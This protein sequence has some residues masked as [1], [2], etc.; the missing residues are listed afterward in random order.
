LRRRKQCTFCSV[1]V[2]ARLLTLSFPLRF[3]KWLNYLDVFQ[4]SDFEYVSSP[5][6]AV[7]ADFSNPLRYL[8]AKGIIP[9]SAVYKKGE[10][11]ERVRPT[12]GVLAKEE[13]ISPPSEDEGAAGEEEG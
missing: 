5:S 2:V 3:S 1:F 7:H 9:A 13:D 4:G 11:P 8:N 6:F 10:N 12:P